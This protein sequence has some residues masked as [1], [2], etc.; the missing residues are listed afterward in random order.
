MSEQELKRELSAPGAH[1]LL[2]SAPSAHLAYV[3]MDGT[4]R[5]VPV[6]Y[7]WTGRE[8]VVSTA[9]TAPK[10]KALSQRADVALSIETGDSPESARALSV[11]GRAEVQIIA[12]VVDEYLQAARRNMDAESAEQF[13]QQCRQMYDQMARIAIIPLWARFYDFGAGRMPK[14]LSELADKARG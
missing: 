12:G 11:R 4:P 13:E 2:E 8:F 14:F 7:W 5:V 1:E 9:V 3:A 6:G 10:V